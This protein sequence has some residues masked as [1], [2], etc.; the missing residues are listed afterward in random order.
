MTVEVYYKK[1][2]FIISAKTFKENE[3]DTEGIYW[4]IEGKNITRLFDVI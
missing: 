1:M 2:A 3:L 4:K